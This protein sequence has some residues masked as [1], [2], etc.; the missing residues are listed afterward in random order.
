MLRLKRITPPR[1]N[2]FAS[3]RNSTGIVVPGMLPIRNCPMS[4]RV[5]RGMMLREL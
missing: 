2:S 3:D 5:A 1:S 4:R